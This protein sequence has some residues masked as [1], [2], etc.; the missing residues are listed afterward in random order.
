MTVS[1]QKYIGGIPQRKL[2]YI[3]YGM[4]IVIS[5]L[6]LFT[7][8]QTTAGYTEMHD[9]TE[10]YIELQSAAYNLQVSSD[11]LTEQV[12]CFVITGK[13]T[14]L[15]AYF[16]EIN[17]ARRREKSVEIFREMLPGT[18]A[19]S[20]IE[21]ALLQSNELAQREMKAIRYAVDFFGFEPS[22]LPAQIRNIDVGEHIN[23]LTAE[24]KKEL[25]QTM[26]FDAAYHSRKSKITGDVQNCLNEL[27][28]D[29]RS[30]EKNTTER[31]GNLLMR[32]QILIVVLLLMVVVVAVMT[33]YQ[34]IIPLLR[35]I[36][37]IRADMPL[38][39]RGA[40]EYRF[41]AE[42]YNKMYQT[43]SERK[44]ELAFEASHDKLTGLYN[45]SGYEDIV[46]TLDLFAYTLLIIDIDRFKGINDTYGHDVGDDVL[47]GAARIMR[48]TFR[49]EDYICRIG[50]DEFVVIMVRAGAEAKTK[51]EEKINSINADLRKDETLKGVSVS[52]GAAFAKRGDDPEKVFKDADNALY[53]AKDVGRK[54]VRFAE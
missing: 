18:V 37:Q 26:V 50:G 4:V 31:L 48:N 54:C 15:N 21:D 1:G 33:S 5:A 30:T 53:E 28:K 42:T 32:Q 35:A 19:L 25:A 13:R 40:R 27:A 43:N 14:Y 10:S 8:V 34:V 3:M 7:T 6:L 45:R 52:A 38:P 11:Y 46:K 17:V 20:E 39:V 12:Q 24:E 29:T 22:E 2:N 36:P 49:S 41:L 47:S 44:K 23:S 9:A 16:D 51:I